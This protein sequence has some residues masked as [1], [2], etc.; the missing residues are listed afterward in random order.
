[1]AKRRSSRSISRWVRRNQGKHLCKCGCGEAIE[2]K[3]EH[4]KPSVGIPSFI[5]GHNLQVTEEE[6]ERVEAAQK[7]ESLWDKLSP[8]EQ[9]RRLS[10]LKSFGKGEDNPSWIGGRR[11]DDNGYV[12]ILMPEHPLAKDGYMAEHRLVVEERTRKE[13]SDSSLLVEIEG[14]KYLISSAVVHHIDEVKTNNRSENLM[15]LEN[16]SAHAFI[17]NS[18]LPMEERLRRIKLGIYHSKPLGD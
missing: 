11:I 3:R 1:V 2:I 16:Q 5:K 4:A 7:E 17:H 14:K 10:H 12:Q 9:R 13:D 18:P 6:L 15:L 8:E